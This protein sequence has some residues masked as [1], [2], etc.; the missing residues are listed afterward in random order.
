VSN[1]KLKRIP[2]AHLQAQI[3]QAQKINRGIGSDVFLIS[4]N[5]QKYILRIENKNKNSRLKLRRHLKTLKI[6]NH[7][8]FTQDAIQAGYIGKRFYFVTNYF[9]GDNLK[10]LTREKM[11]LLWEIAE[12]V[13][14]HAFKDAAK[15]R[16]LIYRSEYKS[17]MD[18][19]RKNLKKIKSLDLK[20][21]RPLVL[22]VSRDFLSLNKIISSRPKHSLLHFDLNKENMLLDSS[23]KKIFLLDWEN[24]MIGD[25][26]ADYAI[27][28]N[29]WFNNSKNVIKDYINSKEE[30]LFI[31]YRR[32]FLLREIF[33]KLKYGMPVDGDIKAVKKI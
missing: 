27:L 23:G 6:L 31:F 17:W 12:K 8:L 14:A 2:N 15:M 25:P 26:L 29:F 11:F 9:P 5:R 3:K 21:L 13:H 22:K 24:A 1:S 20:E 10:S 33:Y 30:K 32:F 4:F 28:N 18:F 7:E 16:N 19:L